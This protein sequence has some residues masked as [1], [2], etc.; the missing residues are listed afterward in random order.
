MKRLLIAALLAGCSR[1][2]APVVVADAAPAEASAPVVDAS[3]RLDAAVEAEAGAPACGP[4]ILQHDACVTP[5]SEL[6][7][8]NDAIAAWLSARGAKPPDYT[9][10]HCREAKL[11]ADAEEALVCIDLTPRAIDGEMGIAGPVEHRYDL[12]VVAVR[13]K[14]RVELLR[15]PF[16]FGMS[17]T[18]FSDYGDMLF[19]ATYRTDDANAVVEL[20]APKRECDATLA[21]L[22]PYWGNEIQEMK[23]N[24]DAPLAQQLA[25]AERLEIVS[26]GERVKATCAAA[27]RYVRANATSRFVRAK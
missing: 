7:M 18:S 5:H 26:D 27:G 13:A 21:E 20:L 15:V 24:I 14:K 4:T 16:A 8:D 3:V 10:E 6:T 19:S 22:G 2:R 12:E 1:S 9:F 11:G 23:K 17:S 25:R